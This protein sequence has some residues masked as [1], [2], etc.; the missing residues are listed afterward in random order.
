VV[1]SKTEFAQIVQT[2]ISVS[3]TRDSLFEMWL[4]KTFEWF[5]QQ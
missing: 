1:V 2:K 5:T 3:G 4:W